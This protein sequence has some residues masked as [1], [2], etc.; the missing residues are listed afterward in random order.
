MDSSD[1]ND[2][3]A[4]KELIWSAEPN[5][6]LP[7][8]VEDLEPGRSLDLAC[9]EGRNTLWLAENGWDAL[10]IDFS[11]VAVEKARRIAAKRGVD[12]HFE[13]GDVTQPQ[14]DGHSMDL[15]IIFYLQLPP[16]QQA[17]V[18]RNAAAAVAPGGLFLLVA[19]DLSNIEHGYGGPQNPANLPTPES[20]VAA[21]EGLTVDRAEV[22]ERVVDTP[23]GPRT[24]LDTFVLAH[25]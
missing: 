16:E 1:W 25:H 11:E 21:L 3:Y 23:E 9:G 8:V 20:T 2:K 24:A 10:G 12:A 5:Q 7:P 19:H 22:V 4:E 18:L 6:F 15:V 13:V 17:K 14:V